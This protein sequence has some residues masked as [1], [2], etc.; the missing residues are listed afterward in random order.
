MHPYNLEATTLILNENA[1]VT[2]DDQIKS[3]TI[4]D[5][6]AAQSHVSSQIPPALKK[7]ANMEVL[8]L[9]M[10][11]NAM[12]LKKEHC[13]NPDILYQQTTLQVKIQIYFVHRSVT[14]QKEIPTKHKTKSKHHSK[15]VHGRKLQNIIHS[16]MQ[17]RKANGDCKN[18][19][20]M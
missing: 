7:N 3:M 2:Y 15:T 4:P 11:S 9:I 6:P 10:F 1:N 13:L 14:R 18:H 17:Y 16:S 19:Q 12:T 20:A 8:K 5:I